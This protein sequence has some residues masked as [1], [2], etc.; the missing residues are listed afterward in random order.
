MS[1]LGFLAELLM[2][3]CDDRARRR[4]ERR[5]KAAAFP[6]EKSLRTFD[7]DANPNI[8]PAVIHT[9][10]TCEWVTKGQ[11][12]CLIGDSGTGES[13]LLIALG[14]EAAMKRFPRQVHPGHQA[15]Q[16]AGRGRRRHGARQ[17]HRPLRTRR[18]ALH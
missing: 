18:P 7:Y 14:T 9:L 3:E 8:G 1:Y 2:A 5:I 12:L 11:P 15:G 4:S 17:D 10:A 6:R 16:R 13:H